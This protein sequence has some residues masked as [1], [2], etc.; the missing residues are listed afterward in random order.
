MRMGFLFG[1]EVDYNMPLGSQFALDIFR[2]DPSKAKQQ[3]KEM[4]DSIDASTSYAGNWLP[5]D[6][7]S[8]NIFTFGKSVYE[9]I[10]KDTIEHNRNKVIQNIN[11]LDELAEAVRQN[12]ESKK[13]NIN[14]DESFKSINKQPVDNLNMTQSIKFR[15]EFRE[16]NKLFGSRFF[17]TSYGI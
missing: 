5:D 16:G 6:Y 11:K 12:I 2:Q 10:I 15:E 13:Q 8:K 3:F 14:I 9:N 4:R 7:Q 1:A 17:F